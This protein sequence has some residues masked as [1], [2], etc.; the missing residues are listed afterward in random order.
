MQEP[1]SVYT[2]EFDQQQN[3]WIASGKWR[4]GKT[5]G[6][7]QNRIAEYVDEN[8][9]IAWERV[10]TIDWEGLTYTIWQAEA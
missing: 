7:L 4:E 8:Q 2:V 9:R 5:P 1:V 10:A 3:E 6:K